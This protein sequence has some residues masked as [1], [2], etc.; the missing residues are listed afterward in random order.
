MT[1]RNSVDMVYKMYADPEWAIEYV[2]AKR[3][4]RKNRQRVGEAWQAA[5]NRLQNALKQI[6]NQITQ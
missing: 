3:Q 1:V 4:E 6:D 2:M 5:G